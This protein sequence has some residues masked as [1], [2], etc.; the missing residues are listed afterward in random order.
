MIVEGEYCLRAHKH[1]EKSRELVN[2]KTLRTNGSLTIIV[3]ADLGYLSNTV[4]G[5]IIIFYAPH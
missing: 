5:Y 1:E 2:V 4:N 3:K